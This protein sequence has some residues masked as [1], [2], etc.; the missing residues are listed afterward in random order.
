[1]SSSDYD[2]RADDNNNAK[3]N[4]KWDE[5]TI[6]EHDKFRGTRRKILEPKT[7][8]RPP[9]NLSSAGSVGSCASDDSMVDGIVKP[10]DPRLRAALMSGWNNNNNNNS[11]SNSNNNDSGSE[12]GKYYGVIM[13]DVMLINVMLVS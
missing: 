10:D 12:H 2:M 3:K 8:Y 13:C 11:N 4:I 1:M 6:A 5:I 7:P 9:R